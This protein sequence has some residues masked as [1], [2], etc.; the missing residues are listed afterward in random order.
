LVAFCSL[1]A[2]FNCAFICTF[3]ETFLPLGSPF[4]PP[5]PRCQDA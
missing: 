2:G 4:A 3:M 5:P 1:A